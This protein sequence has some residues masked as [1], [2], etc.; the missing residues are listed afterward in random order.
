[1]NNRLRL[2]SNIDGIHCF[3]C[4]NRIN[5]KLKSLG[6]DKIDIDIT[7]KI[8]KVDYV[9]QE[10]DSDKFIEAVEELGYKAKKIVVFDP[11]EIGE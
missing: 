2:V 11:S 6:A 10:V 9:G 3:G 4:M 7:T 8:M 1:M 5:T